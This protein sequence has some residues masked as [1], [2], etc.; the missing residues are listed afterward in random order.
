MGNVIAKYMRRNDMQPYYYAKVLDADGN[1]INLTGASIVATMVNED[2]KVAKFTNQACTLNADPTT[3][4][5][6][7]AWGANDTDTVGKFDIEFQVT[8]ASGGKFTVPP[9]GKARVVIK[10]DLDAG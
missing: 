8:P 7:Y 2:T 6:Y 1:A 10:A 4:K 9:K 5:F 3:G